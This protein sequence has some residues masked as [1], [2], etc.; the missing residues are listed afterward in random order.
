MA[1]SLLIFLTRQGA[2]M[3]RAYPSRDVPKNIPDLG[4]VYSSLTITDSFTIQSLAVGLTITHTCDSDLDVYLIAPDQTQVL[5]FTWVGGSGDN[6]LVTLLDDQAPISITDGSAP[7]TGW[8]HPEGSLSVLYGKNITGTWK[9]KVRDLSSG[10]TGT[11]QRWSLLVT[12]CPPPSA[13]SNPN[14]PDGA[15]SVPVNQCLSWSD[16]QDCVAKDVV[17]STYYQGT[18]S[19]SGR[20]NVYTAG[21][22]RT[23]RQIEMWLTISTST[24]LRYFVYESSTL[25]GTYSKI[26]DR[27]V[28]DSGTGTK[29]YSTGPISVPLVAGRAYYI[30][31]GW[32]G[33]VTYF[34]DA[35][36]TNFLSLG[37]HWGGWS[38]SFPPPA[39]KTYS[40]P[41]GR[42]Y[43]QLL[44]TSEPP[45]PVTWDVYFGTDQSA[46]EPTATD[47]KELSYCPLK[48][49][50][51][52]WYWWRVVAK[53]RCT[54][55][56]GPIWS[57]KT[58][59]PPPAD[60]HPPVAISQNVTVQADRNCQG[61]LD[62]NDVDYGSYDPDG[63]PI[64]LSLDPPGPYPIGSHNV[65]LTVA[66][67]TGASATCSATVT[68]LPT[69]YC[70]KRQ[71]IATLEAI[72]TQDPNSQLIQAIGYLYMS[73][74]DNE[75]AEAIAD[76]N[77]SE[78]FWA[79]P[80]RIAQWQ[81]GYAGE[82]VFEYQQTA[83]GLLQA[84]VGATGVAFAYDINNVYLQL[85][86]ADKKL[87]DTAISD[88]VFQGADPSIIA[89]AKA[90]RSQAD[91]VKAKGG[92]E[93]CTV[94]LQ[95][96]EQA[97]QIAIESLGPNVDLDRN[98][99]VDIHDFWIFADE[100]LE[101]VCQP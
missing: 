67:D 18:G 35:L 27:E 51:G 72:L 73:L 23:L 59:P 86:E 32:E 40:D 44:T 16:G 6:F 98:G 39:T 34:Y 9:L 97:W 14:P 80:D 69:A 89:A 7:F 81:G 43:Y 66:D 100:W 41:F 55:T 54:E 96:Y 87:T 91:A 8:Y 94:A 92:R 46:L 50:N 58:E 26:L 48:L 70:Y 21:V 24:K 88:A 22:H 36:D 31:A 101:A 79:G 56:L 10:Q 28:A 42:A 60:N 13:P 90:L 68:A 74:G 77:D 93:I 15:E 95:K 19:G 75:A 49:Q 78:V 84:Y 17:G 4:T 65:T 38:T 63:D 57:F 53:N 99:S 71:A 1:V 33:Q 3:T 64:T 37:F 76:M 20:G 62:A 29:W 12:D 11:L 61:P 2:G 45:P 30:G 47:L 85:A 5:L 25:S 82:K 83:C 52:I